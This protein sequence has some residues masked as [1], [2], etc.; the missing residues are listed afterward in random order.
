MS[1]KISISSSGPAE[2]ALVA[3]E[4][5]LSAQR[6]TQ[7]ARN[8]VRFSTSQFDGH[9]CKPPAKFSDH[10][11]S[12]AIWGIKSR[13]QSATLRYKMGPLVF[14]YNSLN[15]N[16]FSSEADQKGDCGHVPPPRLDSTTV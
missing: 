15:S 1:T 8:F 3:I 10:L 6:W 7:W 11:I 9:G 4:S 14:L 12:T 5:C 13:K 2:R 16:S